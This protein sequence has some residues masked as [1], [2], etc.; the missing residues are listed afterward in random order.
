MRVYISDF[1]IKIK[2]P[3]IYL[4]EQLSV[5]DLTSND[6]LWRI[7]HR[8]YQ[9]QKTHIRIERNHRQNIVSLESL[10]YIILT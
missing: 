2:Y 9:Y 8:I 5:Y 7:S 4:N 6:W 3:S 10:Y 1:A